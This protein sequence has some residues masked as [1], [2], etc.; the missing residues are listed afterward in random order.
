MEDNYIALIILNYNNWEDTI[1]CIKSVE[2]FNSAKI[3]YIV[4]DNGSAEK[5]SLELLDA[6]LC[7]LF[8]DNYTKYN[9]FP[10]EHLLLPYCSLLV[11]STNEGYARGNNLGLKMAMCDNTISHVM[12]LNNDVLFVEDIIPDLLSNLN[13]LKD[14]AIISPVLFKKG[15]I[16]LDETCARM[17]PTAKDLIMECL[18]IALGFNGYRDIIKKKYWLF[19]KNPNL[20]NEK[21]LN[22]EMPSGSCMLLRKDLFS[23]IGFFDPNTFLYFEENILSAKIKR[24]KMTNY[25]LPYLKCIHLG[26]SSTNKSPSAFIQMCGLKSRVYYLRTYCD[27]SIFL[28]ILLGIAQYM[29]RIKICTK[30]ILNK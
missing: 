21:I 27:L 23:R 17:A 14:C 19:I 6:N 29:M 1:N 15:L 26:A 18:M 20:I 12:I 10:T 8:F 9:I 13:T 24:L 3:K 2:L 5:K 25:I 22:I 30:K 28:Q 11:N 16:G 7:Q 4:V